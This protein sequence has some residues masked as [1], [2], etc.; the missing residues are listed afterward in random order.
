MSREGYTF[1]NNA[2]GFFGNGIYFTNR[3]RYASDIHSKGYIFL[4]WVSMSKPFPIKGGNMQADIKAMT[5]GG[6]YKNY[7]A[8]HIPVRSINPSDP[9]EKIYGPP[10]YDPYKAIFFPDIENE[11][12]PHCDEFVIFNK[13]QN[14]TTFFGRARSRTSLC[15]FRY[16][17]IC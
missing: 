11:M 4:A 16:S 10:K 17:T 6:A 9:Y 7:N 8:H 5:G 13:S 2:E 14:P 12:P 15:P 3:A 1:K